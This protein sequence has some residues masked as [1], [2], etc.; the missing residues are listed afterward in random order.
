V[1]QIGTAVEQLYSLS[2]HDVG[3]TRS[4]TSW[5]TLLLPSGLVGIGVFGWVT[6]NLG[7]SVS[8]ALTSLFGVG[9]ALGAWLLPLELQPAT[10][11][12][13][14][15]FRAFLFACMFA[16]LAHEFGY[17]HFGLLSGLVLA[18]GGALTGAVQMPLERALLQGSAGVVADRGDGDGDDASSYRDDGGA[19]EQPT[20]FDALNR[21]Q[22]YC[23]L[24]TFF[25]PAYVAIKQRMR[26]SRVEEQIK[27]HQRQLASVY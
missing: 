12:V 21:L 3:L 26:A 2:G 24:A 6:D 27:Q 1:L 20:S 16:Y 13:Y 14:S 22:L 10:F 25:F 7:F 11:V 9:F 5:F 4:Y 18:A 17:R 19:E 15:F 23:M 8:S